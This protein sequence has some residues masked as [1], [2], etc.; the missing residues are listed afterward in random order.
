MDAVVHLAARV[1]I[2]RENAPDALGAFRAV[3]VEAT[4][5]LIQQCGEAGIQHFLFVSSAKVHGEVTHAR[6]FSEE[7]PPR[8]E[9]PYALSKWEA[10]Q[11]VMDGA[12]GNLAYTILRPPLV[13]GP[14]V[15]GN[16]LS[17]LSAV[18]RRLPLPLDAV[19]NQ[20]SLLYIGNLAASIVRCLEHP[21]A[22]RRTFLVSDGEDF[23]TP[24]LIR[25]LA[26]ALDVS[27]RLIAIPPS[28][29]RAAA[30]L[31]GKRGVAD[32][33]TR[34]L[35]VD[36]NCIRRSLDWLPPY[37]AKEALADTARWFKQ[38]SETTSAV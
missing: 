2:L 34:S 29:L 36:S 17:L 8:P 19:Q 3:N 4:R 18:R 30:S 24:E 7:D 15:R 6:P 22:A 12:T 13:Y 10:E 33:L 14:N 26:R 37:E 16:F 35:Q 38:V 5:N 11:A 1:H 23:S 28:W 9:D 20:R 32:R 21:H 27:P 31:I 25:I